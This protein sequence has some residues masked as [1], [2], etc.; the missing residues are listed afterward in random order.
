MSELAQALGQ[1]ATS[2]GNCSRAPAN[3]KRSV[4]GPCQ[5]LQPEDASMTA[6]RVSHV[7]PFDPH[8]RLASIS[9]Q[10]PAQ[11]AIFNKTPFAFGEV[12]QLAQPRPPSSCSHAT[13]RAPS[14]LKALLG[15]WRH[16]HQSSSTD[17]PQSGTAHPGMPT[18]PRHEPPQASFTPSP[19]VLVTAVEKAGFQL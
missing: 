19:L 11:D 5:L 13:P 6:H 16:C 9:L 14:W 3:R 1:T 10:C 18:V 12:G 4:P 7:L 8:G 17:A 2:P 15:S